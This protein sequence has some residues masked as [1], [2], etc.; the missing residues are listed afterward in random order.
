MPSV[1]SVFD[2][3]EITLATGETWQLT[4]DH[5]VPVVRQS[6]YS[7]RGWELTEV[8]PGNIRQGMFL[9]CHDRGPIRIEHWRLIHF[10]EYQPPRRR[11]RRKGQND[12]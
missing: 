4:D 10:E 5:N 11:R 1:T 2:V 8:S 3:Y 9:V 6:A 7:G 12:D